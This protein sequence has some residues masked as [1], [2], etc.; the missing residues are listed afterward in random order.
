MQ[1]NEQQHGNHPFSSADAFL[2]WMA[3]AEPGLIKDFEVNKNR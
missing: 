2:W 3:T 1:V